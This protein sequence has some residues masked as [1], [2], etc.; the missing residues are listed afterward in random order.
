MC[1]VSCCLSFFIYFVSSIKYVYPKIVFV[2]MAICYAMHSVIHL[3][4]L[5]IGRDLVS[6]HRLTLNSE[7]QYIYSSQESDNNYCFVTLILIYYFR[8]T[9]LSWWLY[10]V[11]T[12][13]LIVCFKVNLKVISRFS[14]HY[15][16]YI[17]W[18]LSALKLVFPIV[19]TQPGTMSELSGLCSIG[20]LDKNSLFYYL[21]L[22]SV[23]YLSLG[24]LALITGFTKIILN[25]EKA[26]KKFQSNKHLVKA[27]FICLGFSLAYIAIVCCELYEF[28]FMESWPQ[29]PKYF[30]LNT[31]IIEHEAFDSKI[32]ILTGNSQK[33]T[34]I[35]PIFITKIFMQFVNAFFILFLVSIN[36]KRNKSNNS[37]GICA[38]FTQKTS[39]NEIYSSNTSDNPEHSYQFYPQQP[40]QAPSLNLP[41]T[42]LQTR[43]DCAYK[44]GQPHKQ[45]DFS[46]HHHYCTPHALFVQSDMRNYGCDC[47]T[48]HHAEDTPKLS[49]FLPSENI[50]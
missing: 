8:M 38:H 37:G 1:L 48:S 7:T 40:P 23:I 39:F 3:G 4:G 45:N 49:T 24:I 27:G 29:L 15:S 18:L 13:F 32:K 31:N 5:S 42:K 30:D 46:E 22:P 21:I 9:A 10:L 26:K 25:R 41:T 17:V 2:Y 35:T 43:C 36:S 33:K 20:D 19:F 47:T 16:H 28:Y 14:A 44:H 11:L 6:C 50:Y 34:V 12:W